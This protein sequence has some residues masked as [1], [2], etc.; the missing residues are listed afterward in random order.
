MWQPLEKKY[1]HRVS[2]K[3]CFSTCLLVSDYLFPDRV[4]IAFEMLETTPGQLR[5]NIQPK[6]PV[7]VVEI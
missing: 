1:R 4:P 7:V 2:D 6:E 5:R 3:V